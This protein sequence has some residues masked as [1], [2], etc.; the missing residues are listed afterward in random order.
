[1]RVDFRPTPVPSR[2]REGR[3]Q[4]ITI[5]TAR[6]LRPQAC[7]LE[8]DPDERARL[9]LRQGRAIVWLE[10][11]LAP[12]RPKLGEAEV[13]RLAIAVRSATG[14]EALAWLTDIARLSRNDARE[15]MRWSARSMLQAAIADN[16]TRGAAP[17]RG[18]T[19]SR[20]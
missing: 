6:R 2:K 10:E 16:G 12:L 19:R 13:H 18:R 3:F 5:V 8:A 7:S 1:M 17:R 9:P 15:L 14:I 11:A 20:R 4:F